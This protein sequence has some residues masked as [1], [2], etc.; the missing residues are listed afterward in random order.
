MLSPESDLPR[1]R[2]LV[3]GGYGTFGRRLVELLADEPRLDILVAGRSRTKAEAFRA[4]LES[5]ASIE[6]IELDREGDIDAALAS[7]WSQILVDVTGPFQAYGAAPYRLAEA[8]LR[9][10]V[11]Y[12]DFSDGSDFTSGIARLDADARAR[13][14]FVL[15]AVSS[16]PAL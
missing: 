16:T 8:C 3:L 15:S 5:A 14:L 7:L 13:G 11:H 1:L 4:T 10:G 2:V 6:A 12:L 9:H